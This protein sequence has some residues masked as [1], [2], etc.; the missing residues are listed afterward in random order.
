KQT[1]GFRGSDILKSVLLIAAASVIGEIYYYFG[2]SEANIITVYILGVLVISVITTRRIYSLLSSLVSVIVF[3]FLFT[4]PQFTLWAYDKDYPITF[5]TMF[6][7]ALLTGSLAERLKNQ[8]KLSKQAAYSTRILFDTNRLLA[9]A[10][11]REEI[12][13]V[14]ATQLIKLL[15][16]SV[17]I[18]LTE[19]DKL[20]EPEFFASDK[21]EETEYLALQEKEAAQ[22]VFKNNEVAGAATNVYKSAKYMYL[23]LGAEKE[24]YG[25]VGIGIHEKPMDSFE[26]SILQSILG[27]CTL[28]LENE[29][30][31]REKAEAAL[32]AHKEQLRANLLRSISHDLRTPLTSISGNASNLLSNAEYFDAETKRQLYLDIYDDS[33]WLISLVENLLS[34]TRIEEGK[35]HLNLS[36]ELLD[37]VIAEAL[38]H[39]DRKKA[40]HEIVVQALEELILV[41]VDARMVMQVIINIVDNAVKYTH[42]GSRIVITFWK[43]EGKAVVRIADNGEGISDEIKPYVF[44]MF[45]S[46]A[47]SIADSRRSLGLGL[48]L[49][50]S[51]IMAHGGELVLSDNA[52]QGAVFTFTLPLEEVELH[53]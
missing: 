11:E 28:V 10:K 17:V 42:K 5:I 22:W 8:T 45:Y 21:Q 47:K 6:G 25:V 39:I 9:K 18:Y 53:E 43:Q 19:K 13:N 50:K 37:E 1:N 34:V 4:K 23:P 27:E 52:P 40:E 32:V 41:K 14:T 29:K 44:E 49:C 33:M 26:K 16:R 12:I 20:S 51:I 30:N 7:V 31:A 38:Q 48:C 35:L 36:A 46:G 15:N 3:N 24:I 2:F